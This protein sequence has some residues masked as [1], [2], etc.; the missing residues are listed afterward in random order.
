M[1]L[2]PVLIPNPH[3]G[4][5][6]DVK[7]PYYDN[8]SLYIKIP[9]GHC[10]EC[11]KKKQMYLVQRCQLESM[12]NYIYMLTLTYNQ[13]HLPEI[14]IDSHKSTSGEIK[15]NFADS[16][17]IQDMFKR[18][19]KIPGFPVK[20]YIAVSE[21]GGKLHRPHWHLLLFVPKFDSDDEYEPLRIESYLYDLFKT[22]WRIN[23][24]STRNPVYEPLFTFQRGL[25]GRHNYDLHYVDPRKTSEG[26]SDVAFYT[27]KYVLKYDD[28]VNNIKKLLYNVCPDFV[29]QKI[30]NIFRPKLL[31][32]KHFGLSDSA[33]DYIQLCLRRFSDLQ[34]TFRNPI[35]GKLFPMSPYLFNKYG[36]LSDIETEFINKGLTPGLDVNYFDFNRD[37]DYIK[38]VISKTDRQYKII[39]SKC[40]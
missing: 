22:E 29:F 2:C 38:K 17:H 27:T 13:E 40:D 1:C 11:T 26:E 24:G 39:K 33:K 7:N 3:R 10:V 14:Y 12:D 23:V 31:I 34:P 19:R 25:D 6:I 36:C 28:Y 32:S 35:D 5:R 18:L 9:C 21:F 20:K 15:L 16:K 37:P 4:V 8:K 30:F